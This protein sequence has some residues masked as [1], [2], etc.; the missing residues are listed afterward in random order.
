MSLK[1]R[2]LQDMRQKILLRERVQQLET[3]ITS[4]DTMLAAADY[5]RVEAE[6][7]VL[8]KLRDSLITGQKESAEKS[9]NNMRDF[10]VLVLELQ[11]WAEPPRSRSNRHFNADEHPSSFERN[12]EVHV[13]SPPACL[14]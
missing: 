13:P 1:L 14:W 3:A 12:N 10:S 8:L 9:N 5:A 2:A 11:N 4:Q 6:T 7:S